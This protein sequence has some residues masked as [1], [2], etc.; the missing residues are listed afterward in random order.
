MSKNSQSKLKQVKENNIKYNVGKDIEIIKSNYSGQKTY[1]KINNI[2]SNT[3]KTPKKMAKID[4]TIKEEKEEKEEEQP[5]K[6]NIQDKE[7]DNLTNEINNKK[8]KEKIKELEEK[9]KQMN[10]EYTNDIQ[11]HKDEIVQNEKDIK[12]LINKNTNLKKSLD[13]LSQRLDKV[14]INS[15][16]QKFKIG[17]K[18]NDNKEEDLHHQLEVKEKE[19]KNQQQLINILKKDNKNIRNILN[20]FGYNENNVNLVEKVHQQYKD[21][22]NLQKNF[23]EYKLS[24]ASSQQN[25]H[26]KKKSYLDEEHSYSRNKNNKKYILN[27]IFT[28]GQGYNTHKN[29][30]QSI[31]IK[32]KKHEFNGLSS[33]FNYNKENTNIKPIFT[34]DEKNIVKKYFDNEEKYKN[35][36]NKINILEKSAIIK[37]KEMNM[38]IKIFENKLKEKENQILE[39]KKEAKEKDNIIITLNVHNRDLKKTSNELISKINVLSKALNDLDQKNQL[40]IK[41]NKEIK[42]SIF[43]IDGIIE[44]KSKEG[45]IIPITI[46]NDIT[47]NNIEKTMN[48]NNE[49]EEKN[50]SNFDFSSEN[51][52]NNN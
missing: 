52:D 35:F 24:H 29:N 25:L 21:L 44:A 50:K 18:I 46:E 13:I 51:E 28:L 47:G 49:K 30:T 8:L 1:T 36:M 43:S 33:S 4:I 37:E 45:S 3:K 6:E 26:S 31:D 22:I 17:N 2:I 39:L 12:S 9:I 5:Q 27:S 20:N 14:I 19:L 48:S 42:N 32:K 7:N 11:K 16:N 23:K 41:K 10:I 15:N 40:M 34:D 38:K